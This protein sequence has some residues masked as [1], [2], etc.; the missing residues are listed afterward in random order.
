MTKKKNGDELRP[1]LVKSTE[2]EHSKLRQAAAIVDEKLS[3]FVL[4][5]ALERAEKILK[6]PAK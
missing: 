2:A 5:A 4:A 3:R 6:N 1:F